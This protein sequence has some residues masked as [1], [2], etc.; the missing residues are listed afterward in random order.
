MFAVLALATVQ[1]PQTGGSS[2]THE[3]RFLI[4]R[5]LDQGR[6]NNTHLANRRDDRQRDSNA[7]VFFG[8][9]DEA[10]QVER[11]CGS[12]SDRRDDNGGPA[13]LDP[14]KKAADDRQGSNDQAEVKRVRLEGLGFDTAEQ[15]GPNHEQT[16]KDGENETH[17][18]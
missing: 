6:A 18:H 1:S 9:N 7:C 5:W 4:H 17:I 14:K 3:L 15:A 10:V 12:C 2:Q 11:Q 13:F 8:L 16:V